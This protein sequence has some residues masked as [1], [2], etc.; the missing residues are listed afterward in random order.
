MK[1][2]FFRW[3][4]I[5]LLIPMAFGVARLRFDADVLDLLPARIPAVQGL[6]LYQD[7]FSNSRELI[8]TVQATSAETAKSA[9]QAIA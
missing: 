2:F 4:W 9:A 6:K 5:V 1:R 8:I 7:H 3:W